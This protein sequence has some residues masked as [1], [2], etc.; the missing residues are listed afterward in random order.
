M[1]DSVDL[2]PTVS[3]QQEKDTCVSVHVQPTLRQFTFLLLSPPLLLNNTYR[4]IDKKQETMD[5]QTYRSLIVLVPTWTHPFS[6]TALLHYSSSISPS[7]IDMVRIVLVM[8]H[9]ATMDRWSP[10]FLP[11]PI[12]VHTLSSLSFHL[13]LYIRNN[14]VIPPVRDSLSLPHS[15]P[16]PFQQLI[17]VLFWVFLF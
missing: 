9:L 8:K 7:T 1:C 13:D 6:L 12:F 10:S 16:S 5:S 15:L 3:S 4:P 2:L 17:R 14:G 11:S